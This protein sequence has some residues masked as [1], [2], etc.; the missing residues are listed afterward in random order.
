MEILKQDILENEDSPCYGKVWVHISDNASSLDG[1][2][3]SQEHITVDKNANLGGVGGFT[4]G[5]I[6]TQK[7]AG[8]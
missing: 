3:D 5:I 2:V 7:R 1:I 4:R 6:E 8:D